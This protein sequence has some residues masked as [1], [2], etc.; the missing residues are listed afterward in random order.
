MMDRRAF[1]AGAGAVLLS[2]PL[3]AEAQPAGKVYRI[4]V[5]VAA[6]SMLESPAMHGFRQGLRDLGYV[7]GRTVLVEYRSAE[8]KAERYPE[9]VAD[10]LRLTVDVIVPFS[11]AALP[12]LSRATKDVPVVAATMRDPVKDGYAKSFAHP[13]GNI[14]GLTLVN[15]DFL[16]KRLQ[17]LSEVV[18][19]ARRLVL[20]WNPRPGAASPD[21]YRA[22]A[23]KLGVTLQVFETRNAPELDRVFPALARSGTQAVILA[24]DPLFSAER[25][26]VAELALRY[27]LPTLSGE[28]GFAEAGGL[29]N[30]G[31]SLFDNF[32]R[33]ASYID[34]ILKGAKAQDLAIEQPT[35][36]ELVINLRTAKALGLTIPQSLLLRADEVIQ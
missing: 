8:G 12:A 9:L 23:G 15:E 17:I 16:A 31:P 27:R 30:F 2:A 20:L 7:E 19:G 1:L 35:K 34:R 33:A 18:P 32:R 11:I 29:M 10:L 3:A 13:G 25:K 22:A 24:Q 4:G 6:D 28:T 36:F 26:R 5:L 21:I 14:T